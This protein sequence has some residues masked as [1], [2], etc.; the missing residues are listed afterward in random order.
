MVEAISFPGVVVASRKC[1]H[2]HMWVARPFCCGS[3]PGAESERHQQSMQVG[4]KAHTPGGQTALA[5][6]HIAA[7]QCC[8]HGSTSF[9]P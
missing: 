6:V 8:L 5:A 3:W 4:N 1:K 7:V 9:I 2:T